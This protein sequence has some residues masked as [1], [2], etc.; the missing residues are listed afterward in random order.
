MAIAN[1]TPVLKMTYQEFLDWA[2]EDTRAEWVNGEVEFM[3]PVSE[4]HQDIGIFLLRMIGDFLEDNPL[5]KLF[6]E[7]FQMKTTP[8]GREPDILFVANANL[9]R[10]R[11]NFLEGAA[12]L[13][14]EIVSPESQERDRNTKY[15]EYQ[16]AGVREYWLI[17]L[18][19]QE[20]IFY[21]LQS[22]GL[23]T[24]SAI[25]EDGI[26]H[27]AVLPGLWIQV[28]WLWQRPLPTMRSVRAAWSGRQT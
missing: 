24:A 8:S 11:T 12:D 2:G 1:Q 22:D 18:P 23:Y 28:E 27:S 25:G 14:V 6:Y 7:S 10:V 26:Y 5:G 19:R 13:V 15:E 17:D 4:E 21:Q 20:A 9:S 16:C 3:S